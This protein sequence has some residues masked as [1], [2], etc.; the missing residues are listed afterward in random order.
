LE[1]LP[2]IKACQGT[3]TRGFEKSASQLKRGSR[4][5][6]MDPHGIQNLIKV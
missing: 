4:K 6:K 5:I 3:R 1:D 2:I